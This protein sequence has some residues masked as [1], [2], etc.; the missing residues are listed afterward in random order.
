[1]WHSKSLSMS[2]KLV[3]DFESLECF[4]NN[5]D[6]RMEGCMSVTAHG[7]VFYNKDKYD[8]FNWLMPLILVQTSL[9]FIRC[10]LVLVWQKYNQYRS[11]I[12][13]CQFLIISCC[14]SIFFPR[15]FVYMSSESVDFIQGS[16]LLKFLTSVCFWLKIRQMVIFYFI[17]VLQY[18]STLIK[19]I[20][21]ISV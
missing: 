11:R 15:I 5:H 14:I 6:K 10:C 3:M 13:W 7:P 20:F 18:I 21:S 12:V 4:P 1:M 8:F 16:L 9:V 2:Q 19:I 17:F